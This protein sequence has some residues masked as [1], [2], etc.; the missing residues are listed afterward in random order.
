MIGL[1]FLFLFYVL[2]IAA[3]RALASVQPHDLEVLRQ[4]VSPAELR[5]VRVA[6]AE[7][8]RSLAAVGLGKLTIVLVIFV[9]ISL[10]LLAF[11]AYLESIIQVI[12]WSH[13]ALCCTL[14]IPIA[15]CAI[16]ILQKWVGPQLTFN[17]PNFWLIRLG[18]LV[19]LCQILYWPFLPTKMDR[20]FNKEEKTDL[21]NESGRA[22]R[23]A[24]MLKSIVKFG[25]VSVRSV[26]QPRAKIFAIDTQSDFHEVLQLIRDTEFSRFPVFEDDLDNVVGEI[27][28][29]DLVAYINEPADFNWHKFIRTQPFIVPETKLIAELLQE[30]KAQKRHL[31]IVVDEHGGTEGL[32][33]MEDILEEVTGEIRDEFDEEN[34]LP[35]HSQLDESHFIF[36]G[37][38]P[39]NDVCRLAGLAPDAFDE[40]RED[41][42]T[43]AGLALELY[44]EIPA[45]GTEIH[46]KNYIFYIEKADQRKII[47]ISLT[48]A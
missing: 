34:E 31:S 15:T 38:T 27:Y 18:G 36:D 19:R 32:V 7:L 8:G 21:N 24:E 11:S 1:L 20:I 22:R 40:V 47:E 29:K 28:V 4:G 17:Q 30:F 39:L 44:G 10:I 26:M 2:L 25:D 14:A 5:A 45:A 16:W 33:T 35:P 43:I 42:E 6:E 37:Q 41:A 23:D 3:E 48:I 46:W 9:K 12:K 13:W